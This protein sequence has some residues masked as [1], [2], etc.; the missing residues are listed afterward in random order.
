MNPVVA[1][2]MAATYRSRK[3]VALSAQQFHLAVTSGLVIVSL[4]RRVLP[5]QQALS[6]SFYCTVLHSLPL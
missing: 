6:S 5:C 1:E 2:D 4:R 3:H